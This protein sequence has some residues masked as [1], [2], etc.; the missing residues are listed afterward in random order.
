MAKEQQNDE[1]LRGYFKLAEQGKGHFLIHNDLLHH[2]DKIFGHTV[3]QLVVP[4]SRRKQV[5]EMG[6]DTH[7]GHMGV[8]RT[9]ERIAYTFYWPTLVEDCKEHVKT[10]KVCQL[11]KRVTYADRVPIRA[12]SRANKV[13][14][15]WFIDCAGPF[16]SGEG[17][18]P[19]YNY[20]FIAV[21][22][23]SRFP[24][25]FPMK[26]LHA[27]SVCNAL[28]SLF[29]YTGCCTFI[30]S[31]LGTNF[32]SQLTRE[33]EKRIGCTPR[34]N[35]PWHPNSTGLVERAVGSIKCIVSKLAMDHPR[36]WH[37]YMP[38]VMW[39]LRESSNSTTGV[40]PWLLVMGHLPKGPLAI[41]KDSWA[42][43]NDLP[44]SFGKS[45]TAYLKDLHEKLKVARDYAL[46]HSEREQKRYT[47]HYNLRCKDKQ[48]VVGDHATS[49]KT[50]SKWMGP[51]TEQIDLVSIGHLD[52][53]QQKELLYLLDKYPER[54]F[55]ISLVLP[56]WLLVQ[57]H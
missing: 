7:G 27:K 32:T 21:D 45:N 33:F 39:V 6:H 18:K 10:C 34:L 9:R 40:P 5:L 50:F 16:F 19:L 15:H 42:D 28:L 22:S 56:M 3:F 53:G 31:D 46:L 2:Q 1:S 17:S 38:S 8:K 29:Q 43:D 37:S 11:K 30:S 41:L 57:Y 44:V 48:F 54:F 52:E 12:I 51:P 24:A 36:Q 23:F 55:P 49:S 14:D 4:Q 20:A 26:N 35:S 13:F 47:D 25:C